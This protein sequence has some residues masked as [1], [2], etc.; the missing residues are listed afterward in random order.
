MDN[1]LETMLMDINIPKDLT[2]IIIDYK[3]EMENIDYMDI[4]YEIQEEFLNDFNYYFNGFRRIRGNIY[5]L[6]FYNRDNKQKLYFYIDKEWVYDCGSFSFS[7]INR[8]NKDLKDGGDLDV[9]WNGLWCSNEIIK[10]ILKMTIRKIKKCFSGNIEKL[11]IKQIKK[12]IKKDRS[13]MNKDNHLIYKK[14]MENMFKLIKKWDNINKETRE[15]VFGLCLNNLKLDN[16]SNGF[17]V[18][19]S[20]ITSY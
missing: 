10:K 20:H 1:L 11:N 7:L 12:R 3:N 17:M 16:F 13:R 4:Y 8:V 6:T 2:K 18:R 5:R 19:E 14:N 9:I 15:E